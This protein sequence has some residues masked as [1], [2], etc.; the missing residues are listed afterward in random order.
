MG[1]N[2]LSKIKSLGCDIY[3]RK[4]RKISDNIGEFIPSIKSKKRSL[5][6]NISILRNK[7]VKLSA[8]MKGYTLSNVCKTIQLTQPKL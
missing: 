7:T 2:F 3:K 8:I 4:S 1:I 6:I 5:I